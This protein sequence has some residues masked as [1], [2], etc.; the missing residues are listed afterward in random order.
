MP[1]CPICRVTAGARFRDSPYWTCPACDCWFQSPLP[2]KVYEAAHEKDAHGGSAGHLMSDHDKAVNRALA[3]QLFATCL[4][5]IPART[6]DVGSKY[7]YLAHCLRDL[8]CEAFGM[9]N[10]EIVPEYARALEVPMLMADFEAITEAQIREWTATERF[11]LITL[12]HVFEHMY[13]PLAALAKLRRLVA[14]DGHVFIRLPD[15]GVTGFERDLTAGHYTI[16]PYFHALPSVLELLVQGRDLFAVE[17]TSTLDGAGQRDVV[18][19]PLARKPVILAGLIVKNEERDLPRCLVSIESTVDGVVVVDTGSTD[20]TLAVAQSTIDKPVYARTYTDASRQDA[21]GDWKLWDFGKARNVFVEEIE[22]RGADWA[23][24]MDADDELVTPANLRRAVYWDAFDVYGVQID[25]GGQ[26][27][28][29]HRLWKTGRGIR[30]EG[31]CHEYPTLG[32]HRAL[33]L[34]DSVIRHDAAPGAGESANARNLRILSEEC[35]Q[36]PTPRSVFYLANTLKDGGRWRE[37]VEWYAKR[38]AMGEGF[39][40]EWLF[41]YLYKARCERAAG[42]VAVAERT[43]LEATSRE[44]GWAEFWMEL[45]YIAYDQ[46]RYA[47]TIGY[48]LQAADA[49]IP[50]TL[51]WREPNKYTDQP[52]RLISWCHEHQGDLHAALDWANRARERIGVPDAEWD[53][54]IRRLQAG[55]PPARAPSGPPRIALHR[56][57]AIG[58]IVMTLNLIPPL[59]RAYPGRAIHYACDHAIGVALA[60]LMRAAGVEVVEDCADF[61]ARAQAYERSFNLIGYPIGEGYP[62]RPMRRHL[63]EYFAAE[64]GLTPDEWPSLQLPRPPRPADLPD[65]Y[66]TLQT[67]SGWSAYKHWRHER[68]EALL[69]SCQDIPVVQLG[70]ANEPRIAG[71]RHDYM[72]TPLST[73]IALVANATLHVGIDSFANHLTNYRWVDAAGDGTRVPA[74]IL[75]GS[76]QASA[77]GYPHNTNVSLGLYCQPCFRE[78]PAVSRV[79]R[80][81]CINPPG[82]VYA[83]PRHACMNG[84]AVTRVAKEVRRA[85]DK[86]IASSC[87]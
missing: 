23:L 55:R 62:E 60:D 65:S 27:W 26:R 31:R 41:A 43:L 21:S 39:R 59:K 9:D 8:G 40:D 82:Q 38:I 74:V 25:S 61:D 44:R 12:V 85:W 68:W 79:P 2:S 46:R 37:A 57:G 83:E 84:L 86:A 11:A 87:V 7:P 19:R 53:A 66:A 72:G 56:P 70:T 73:A 24:W 32:G 52:A 22:R 81:P 1:A 47:H 80:G 28:V 20:R 42:D 71:A 16:H 77:A 10:I 64:M 4:R 18:L 36:M 17:S 58:D 29:H 3:E 6:L 30:F 5:S 33:I 15:H 13:D 49:P 76:T 54:R 67:K 51:L 48:A 34:T 45:A 75:W 69:A 14:D 63:I 35:A 50:P 78:D